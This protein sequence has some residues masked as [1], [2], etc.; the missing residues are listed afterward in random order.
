[1]Y[2][3]A[4]EM[5]SFAQGYQNFAYDI[6]SFAQGTLANA[7]GTGSFAQ[8]EN[9]TA[10]AVASFAQGI[11]AYARYTGQ[12]DRCVGPLSSKSHHWGSLVLSGGTSGPAASLVVPLQGTEPVVA[13]PGTTTIFE[14]DI[15]G[16]GVSG[17]TV[18]R[19]RGVLDYVNGLLGPVETV[20]TDYDAGNG[21]S[22]AITAGSY[23][24]LTVSVSG[25]F[26]TFFAHIRYLQF[27]V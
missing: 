14:I 4:T 3:E 1:L 21:L 17:A 27:D 25:G 23:G 8:G 18:W 10:D 5:G 24:K 12:V 22:L 9:V 7:N 6:G 13:P 16:S 19:R 11:G 26:G 15:V 2:S 20:G